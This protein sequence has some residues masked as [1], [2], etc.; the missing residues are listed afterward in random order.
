[1]AARRKTCT[2]A[3]CSD[4]CV[5]IPLDGNVVSL[6]L[7]AAVTCY[8][9]PF[10]SA[11]CCWKVYWSLRSYSSKWIATAFEEHLS[12]VTKLLSILLFCVNLPPHLMGKLL[13]EWCWQCIKPPLQ[14]LSLWLPYS[15][16]PAPKRLLVLAHPHPPPFLQLTTGEQHVSRVKLTC[17]KGIYETLSKP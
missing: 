7:K 3:G 5:H 17:C 9:S 4:H 2:A 11:W 14:S 15:P 8:K 6:S 1:M 13:A 12:I 10:L 16:C